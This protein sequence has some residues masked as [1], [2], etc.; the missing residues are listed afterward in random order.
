MGFKYDAMLHSMRVVEQLDAS[1]YVARY[2]HE[3]HQC[4]FKQRRETLCV[5]RH[6]VVEEERKYVLAGCSIEHPAVPERE[7]LV[8][9]QLKSCGWVIERNEKQPEHAIVSYITNINFGGS[10][11]AALLKSIAKK[12]PLAIL[13]LA[14]EL[15]RKA[16]ELRRRR[17]REQRAAA[18]EH[19]QPR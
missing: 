1:T 14:K 16:K 2:E 5:I 12:Q 13:H 6:R 7:K 4:Y 19:A 9:I 3:N 17:R 11:P 15:K 10:L 8:R 18:R